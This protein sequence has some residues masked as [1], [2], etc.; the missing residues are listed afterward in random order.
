MKQKKEGYEETYV[1]NKNGMRKSM[2]IFR[3]P[4]GLAPNQ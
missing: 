4:E 1:A 2:K 3:N